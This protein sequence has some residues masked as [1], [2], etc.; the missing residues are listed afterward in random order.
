ML[1]TTGTI[2]FIEALRTQNASVRHVMNLETCISII[3]AYFYSQFIE[4]IK[5]HDEENPSQ[6]LPYE[7]I[8]LTRYTDWLLSTPIML[9]VLC[10]VLGMERKISLKVST[11]FIVLLLDVGMLAMGYLG[12]VKKMNKVLALVLGFVFFALL[13][14]IHMDDVHGQKELIRGH[15]QLPCVPYILDH[16]V[17]YIWQMKNS[18]I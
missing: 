9:L 8:N 11:F 10:I 13:Y 7:S 2:T 12:E 16:T 4:I 1:I 6:E 17:L 14:I 15:F 18:K 5:K 3:A